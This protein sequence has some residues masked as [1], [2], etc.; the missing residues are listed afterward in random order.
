MIGVLNCFLWLVTAFAGYQTDTHPADVIP[1][2]SLLATHVGGLENTRSEAGIVSV[3]GQPFNSAIRVVVGADAAESNATQFTIRNI[4]PVRKADVLLASFSIRGASKDGKSPAQA[5][6]L[7]ER[8]VSP[9]TKSVSQGA[10]SSKNPTAWKRINVPFISAEDYSSG[11]VMTSRRFA[12][13]RQ[14]VEIGGLT[15]INYGNTRSLASLQSMVVEQNKLGSVHVTVRRDELQQTIRGFGGNFCQARYGS[16]ETLDLVGRY[17]L[18]HLAV[19][20]ARS[21]I[22]L[23]NQVGIGKVT[24][25]GL[26][27]TSS[28]MITTRNSDRKAVQT[29][30]STD[31]S[32]HVTIEMP[33]RSVVTVQTTK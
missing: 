23:I 4:S 10:T 27:P 31:T 1:T 6:L 13:G 16:K 14:I 29:S 2:D 30:G 5:M 21:G 9:W 3:T 17:N 15:V 33:A 28:I 26:P 18:E 7:F 24:L 12:F 25:S 8:T 32:G 22:L 11:E 19:A 20:H